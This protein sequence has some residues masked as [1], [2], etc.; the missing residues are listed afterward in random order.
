MKR[1]S[2]GMMVATIATAGCVAVQAHAQSLP[3]H[4]PIN[5]TTGSPTGTW[6]PVAAVVAE[7]VN[8]L[9]QGQPVSVTPSAGGVANVLSV[10]SGNA[11]IGV[12]YAPFLRL[13]QQGD[14][15][16]YRQAFPKLRALASMVS[17]ALHI[18]VAHD[19]DFAAAVRAGR[20]LVMATGPTGSTELF[21]IQ[22]VLT[23]YGSSI[24]AVRSA[25]GRVELLNTAGRADGWRNRQFEVV[26]FFIN[27]PAADII[28][29]MS[30]RPDSRILSI[31][32]A[33]ASRIAERWGML[34]VRMPPGTYPN[35]PAEVV[36]LGMPYIYFT[37]TELDDTMAYNIVKSIAENQVRLASAASAFNAWKPQEMV[38]GLGIEIHPGAARYY[39]ERGW[40]N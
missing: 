9:Y 4:P 17:N 20:P 15:E 11:Q 26:N 13:A 6:F 34:E 35:Q 28:S 29:L 1:R 37:T 22:E 30:A 40:I 21:M 7:A 14:N 8:A 33:I 25:G 16:M 27:P 31:E 38:K 24:A 5:F 2:F 18:V 12:S 10:G 3:R 19:M 36:T 32:H 23:G 39:R